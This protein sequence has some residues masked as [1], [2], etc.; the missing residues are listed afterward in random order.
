MSGSRGAR[1]ADVKANAST[2][3]RWALS[4]PPP[5]GTFCWE[6]SPAGRGGGQRQEDPRLLFTSVSWR[7]GPGLAGDSAGVSE[8]AGLRLGVGWS[9]LQPWDPLLLASFPFPEA[10]PEAGWTH[11]GLWHGHRGRD[12]TEGACGL[13]GHP[14]PPRGMGGGRWGSC[15]A[16]TQAGSEEEEQRPLSSCPTKSVQLPTQ[17]IWGLQASSKGLA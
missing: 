13:R 17:P 12:H 2:C 4:P 9:G 8:G 6:V 15:R 10:T 1:P 7:P 3:G 14:L 5:S 16:Q 11:V